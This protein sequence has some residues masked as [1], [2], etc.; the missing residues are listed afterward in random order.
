MPTPGI[1][2]PYW[3]EWYV[4]I[5]NII[6]MLNPNIDYVAIL[7]ICAIIGANAGYTM[8][9]ITD[10]TLEVNGNSESD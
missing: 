3:F 6:K 1:A 7:E 10:E 2:D 8:D 9:F 4:G 5:E